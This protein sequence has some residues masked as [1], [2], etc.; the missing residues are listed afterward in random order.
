M[1]SMFVCN[2]CSDGMYGCIMCVYVVIVCVYMYSHVYTCV[3]RIFIC[4]RAHTQAREHRRIGHSTFLHSP[5]HQ[6]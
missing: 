3:W 4:D 2:A 1:E 6:A 5:S